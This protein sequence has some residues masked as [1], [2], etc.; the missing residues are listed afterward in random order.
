MNKLRDI[1]CCFFLLLVGFGAA[2]VVASIFISF[3]LDQF[4][5]VVGLGL[6]A[7]LLLALFVGW[8]TDKKLSDEYTIEDI[9][10][11]T[12]HVASGRLQF[13]YGLSFRNPCEIVLDVPRGDYTVRATVRRYDDRTVCEHLVVGSRDLGEERTL[14]RMP[15]GFD[16]G[17]LV[18]VDGTVTKEAARKE[19]LRGLLKSEW[20]KYYKSGQTW[21]LIADK[22]G[23]ICLIWVEDPFGDA[24]YSAMVARDDESNVQ[25]TI[26][27]LEN[28][29]FRGR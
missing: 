28:R 14:K 27:F 1:N 9:E 18:I 15:L 26:S 12:L 7:S 4:L 24:E 16:G 20:K 17:P 5:I 25:V 3:D 8:L 21:G 2:G 29:E 23:R 10:V 13:G 6:L 11:G 22:G 19:P